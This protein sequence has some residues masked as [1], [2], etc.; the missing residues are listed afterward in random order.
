MNELV[1][2]FIPVVLKLEQ[3]SESPEGWLKQIAGPRP[4]FLLTQ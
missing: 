2:L 3:G 1:L 4:H